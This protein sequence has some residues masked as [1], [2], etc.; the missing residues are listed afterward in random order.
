MNY[1]LQHTI[2]MVIYMI[3]NKEIIDRIQKI[4]D[5][6]LLPCEIKFLDALIEAKKQDKK[7]ML[8]L[9]RQSS[10]TLD[11]VCLL[12]SVYPKPLFPKIV[13]YKPKSNIV[14]NFNK[15]FV[16]DEIHSLKSIKLEEAIKR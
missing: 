5:I 15:T 14:S 2:F 6:K 12:Y 13:K 16:Y 4:N 10:R 11:R 7:I 9:A 3:K 8:R 1:K